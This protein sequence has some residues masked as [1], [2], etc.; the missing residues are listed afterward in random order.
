[1][2]P[3]TVLIFFLTINTIML[4]YL[5][6]VH[7]L[8]FDEQRYYDS[9]RENNVYEMRSDADV[10]VDNVLNFYRGTAALE[11][12]YYTPNEF[13]HL[14]D[15][16]R[17]VRKGKIVMY[18]SLFLEVVLVSIMI[19]WSRSKRI[20]TM[21]LAAGTGLLAVA[22]A[23]IIGATQFEAF[24]L[25]FHHVFFPQGNFLFPS[26]SVLLVMYPFSFFQETFITLIVRAT[27]IGFFLTIAGLLL[28][29]PQWKKNHYNKV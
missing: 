6:N 21:L 18:A 12:S 26:D 28:F 27:L 23:F 29:V 22:A 20:R 3:D 16:E 9:F 17:L 13:S 2:K 7:V 15:V 19:Y 11:P 14:V 10:I 5:L 8:M 1:M 4:V 24:F 25:G